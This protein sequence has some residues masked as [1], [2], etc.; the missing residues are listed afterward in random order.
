MFINVSPA[1]LL[2]L[3]QPKFQCAYKKK[4]IYINCRCVGVFMI[5]S[6]AVVPTPGAARRWAFSLPQRSDSTGGAT[7]FLFRWTFYYFAIL[8]NNVV[9]YRYETTLHDCKVYPLYQNFLC[10]FDH[11]MILVY[12]RF[13]TGFSGWPV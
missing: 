6:D 13:R 7:T 9:A 11:I 2:S 1:P 8:S 10:L 12:C 3:L 5:W 4:Y